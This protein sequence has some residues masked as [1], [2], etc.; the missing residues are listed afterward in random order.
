MREFIS[1]LALFGFAFGSARVITFDSDKTGSIPPGWSVAWT[2]KKR[3]GHWE[4]TTDRTAPSR[5]NVFAQV[6]SVHAVDA[7]SLALFN[8]EV[9]K[10]GSVSV[11]LKI[12]SGTLQQSAGL[13]WR[14]ED[15][16]DFYFAVA[17]ADRK[18][19]SIYKK[20]YGR[21]S[22][23]AHASIPHSVNES[24]WNVMRIRF[25]DQRI[26]LYFGHRKLID[27]VDTSLSHAGKTGVWTRADTVAFFDN[28]RV[29]KRE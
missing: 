23:L 22:L 2:D 4:I 15:A 6:A 14:Y 19:V 18:T 16:D 5:F 20:I 3:P 26:L 29:D 7:Y 25:N 9:C 10:N 13:L 17:S 24:E 28:F 8:E 12:V 1:A 21:A 27:T 11:D